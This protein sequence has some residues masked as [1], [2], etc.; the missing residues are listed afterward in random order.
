[1]DRRDVIFIGTFV[2]LLLIS[3]W[4]TIGPDYLGPNTGTIGGYIGVLGI[5][6]Y[7]WYLY[8]KLTEKHQEKIDQLQAFLE[9]VPS[10]EDIPHRSTALAEDQMELVNRLEKQHQLFIAQFVSS[11]LLA[12]VVSIWGFLFIFAAAPPLDRF[13]LEMA[14]IG[15]PF[16]LFLILL[17]KQGQVYMVYFKAMKKYLEDTKT[18]VKSGRG[19]VDIT[20]YVNLL[21]TV[22]HPDKSKIEKEPKQAIDQ[23]RDYTRYL[24]WMPVLEIVVFGAVL[25]TFGLMFLTLGVYLINELL[26]GSLIWLAVFFI[27]LM[28]VRYWIFFRWRQTIKRWLKVYSA[29]IGWSDDLEQTFLDKNDAPDE[30]G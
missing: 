30:E 10:E 13:I 15:V 23:I 18:A 3:F 28:V 24:K 6:I 22:I 7:S 8:F 25:A 17:A 12:P 4:F 11:L 14:M 2:G 21:F 20:T 19:D 29:L 1:M 9:R 26:I 27:V 5:V 16:A